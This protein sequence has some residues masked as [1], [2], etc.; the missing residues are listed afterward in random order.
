MKR[1]I[2]SRRSNDDVY[3]VGQGDVILKSLE[4][5]EQSLRSIRLSGVNSAA[6]KTIQRF[7]D[8]ASQ[9]A[10][11]I[12][13]ME[14]ITWE[15][16]SPPLSKL[17]EYSSKIENVAFALLRDALG[18]SEDTRRDLSELALHARHSSARLEESISRTNADIKDLHDRVTRETLHI[19]SLG[20]SLQD[21]R[22]SQMEA[23]NAFLSEFQREKTVALAK[24]QEQV[25][26]AIEA[27][28]SGE[29]SK[30]KDHLLQL[31]KL[32]D[33]A[34]LAASMVANDKISKYYSES[35]EAET[36]SARKWTWIALITGFL[37]SGLIATIIIISIYNPTE[38]TFA[39]I[40]R[41]LAPLIG[42]PMFIYAT[43]ESRNHRRR[44][45]K[46]TDSA[47]THSTIGAM[48]APLPEAM[49]HSLLLQA[50]QKMYVAD[51]SGSNSEPSSL[52]IPAKSGDEPTLDTENN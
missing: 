12:S 40:I 34:K 4:R 8:L 9:Q 7:S 14:V 42:G 50:A 46:L 36:K 37:I 43:L 13:S 45:W 41:V 52:K 5:A 28:R 24:S 11:T 17:N 10:Q 47:I 3:I 44:A 51:K 29:E 6:V 16:V 15:S 22:N 35:A 31:E 23:L 26:E 25:A 1:R 49:Q 30:S 18:V 21:M 48:I 2:D 39:S 20:D 27:I 38:S 33:S 19:S 32:V